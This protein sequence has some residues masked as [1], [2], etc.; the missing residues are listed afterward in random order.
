MAIIDIKV[1]DIGDFAE[2]GVI[3]LLVQPGD[4]V[5]VDQSLITVESDKASM[6]IPSSHAGVVKEVKVKIGDKVAKPFSGTICDTEIRFGI[7]YIKAGPKASPVAVAADMVVLA[8]DP[9]KKKALKAKRDAQA[10]QREKLAAQLTKLDDA[11]EDVQSLCSDL[12]GMADAVDRFGGGKKSIEGCLKALDLIATGPNKLTADEKNL[13]RL[14]ATLYPKVDKLYKKVD[15]A[16]SK[17]TDQAEKIGLDFEGID[18]NLA[19]LDDELAA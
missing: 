14:F 10:K 4:S 5:T 17:A 6:E 3:E 8:I 18:E 7:V 12:A 19:D 11:V 15:R 9:A 13:V 2:V 1:P 16:C